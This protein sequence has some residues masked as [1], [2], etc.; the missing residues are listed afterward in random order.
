MSFPSSPSIIILT[1]LSI[2]SLLTT[3]LPFTL[4]LT[5]T[6]TSSSTIAPFILCSAYKAHA[7][8]GTPC[9]TLSSTEFHPQCD[10]NA[11]VDA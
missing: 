6:P 2:S 7:I 8:K 1:T 10:K 5:P 9:F 11:P 4:I 3:P